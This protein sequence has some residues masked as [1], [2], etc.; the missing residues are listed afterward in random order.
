[1]QA[2]HN[3]YTTLSSVEW[4]DRGPT[5]PYF[6]P[7]FVNSQYNDWVSLQHV[8]LWA[9]VSLN[10]HANSNSKKSFFPWP[11]FPV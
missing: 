4:P 1:M 7:A 10:N 9:E 3:L 8:L 6:L 2:Q 5:Q 11:H